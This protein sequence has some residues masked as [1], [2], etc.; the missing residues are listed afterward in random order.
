VY[1]EDLS[2]GGFIPR[3]QPQSPQVEAD[4]MSRDIILNKI[5]TPF[6]PTNPIPP[7][8]TYKAP[9]PPKEKRKNKPYVRTPNDLMLEAGQ[10]ILAI[11]PNIDVKQKKYDTYKKRVKFI[12]DNN[13]QGFVIRQRDNDSDLANMKVIQER[14]KK[15]NKKE[16]PETPDWV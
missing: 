4:D 8:P 5:Y 14:V 7:P 13:N 12:N 2:D 6:D 9:Q 1:S 15:Q 16:F 10:T 3:N 11:D